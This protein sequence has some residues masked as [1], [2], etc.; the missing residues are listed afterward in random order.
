MSQKCSSMGDDMGRKSSS[1]STPDGLELSSNSKLVALRIDVSVVVDDDDDV[2][3]MVEINATGRIRSRFGPAARKSIERECPLVSVC[4]RCFDSGKV[5]LECG[6]LTGADELCKH[7]QRGKSTRAQ[8]LINKGKL[9]TGEYLIDFLH[10]AR[11]RVY[12][13]DN[14]V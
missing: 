10:R 1:T 9:S 11:R 14:Y 7:E 3:R 5:V 4:V 8:V 6:I 12:A 13:R 2:S